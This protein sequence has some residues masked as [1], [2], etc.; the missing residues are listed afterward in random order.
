VITSDA[1]PSTPHRP[2]ERRE[3]DIIT[4][5]LATQNGILAV[6]IACITLALGLRL[7]NLGAQNFWYDE[8]E[9]L[10]YASNLFPIRDIH[11][12]TYYAVAHLAMLL[13]S[14]EFWIRFPSFLMGVA[15]VVI[16]YYIGRLLFVDRIGVTLVTT[17][18]A[19]V[20]P[21]LV[22]HSQDARMYSQF[23]LACLITVYFY[24]QII[25]R[26]KPS[27][28]LGYLFGALFA[29]YTQLYAA[30][31]VAALSCHLLF[32]HRR[33]LLR[34]I[35]FQFLL[36]LGY[37]PWLIIFLNLPPEQIG[38]SRPKTLVT[39][40]YSYYTFVNGYSLGP[41]IRELRD[42]SLSVLYP[43]LPL[44][45]PIMA[46]VAIL[47][48]AGVWNLWRTNRDRCAFLVLWA[49]LPVLAAV[50]VPIVVRSMTYNVRYVIFS[51]PAFLFILASGGLALRRYRIGN[52]L[53]LIVV[54]YSGVALNNYYFDAR[55]AKEDV[56]GAAAYVAANAHPDDHILV[57]TVAHIFDWYF[58]KPNMMVST[59]SPK[60][61][62]AYVNE[63]V[64]GTNT[65]WL[66]ESRPW[67]TDPKNEIKTLLDSHYA[68]IDKSD[69][70][71][72]TLYRYCIADCAPA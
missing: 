18:L 32:F 33:L 57:I 13:G 12:P 2:T 61:A 28:W 46:V 4:G 31:L 55:Y 38:G 68:L 16:I 5:I 54:I 3:R 9:T 17:L 58:D 48:G 53:L 27:D 50:L 41:T 35:T 56:R 25:K 21:M 7:F 44:I 37:V 14:S 43:Y 45:I 69:F 67:Q 66:V 60:P 34:W 63:A 15:T 11:P 22:W 39:F 29:A 24:V 59:L 52:V 42:F 49:V 19:A 10:A 1:Q 62:D 26:G 72:V 51:L 23:L 8:V 64:S 20:S 36:L 6:F 65:L 71:G 70:S 40:P 47:T 30:F